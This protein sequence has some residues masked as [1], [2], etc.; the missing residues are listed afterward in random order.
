MSM[1]YPTRS[2]GAIRFRR[3]AA[4]RLTAAVLRLLRDVHP[5][6][7]GREVRRGESGQ[8]V[9]EQF[10]SSDRMR[11]AGSGAPDAKKAT[12]RTGSRSPR[13]EDSV[14]YSRLLP[15]GE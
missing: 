3:R 5:D 2:L 1:N 11:P 13:E 9:I 4:W 12:V 14:D 10:G 8:K 6:P 15:F 7:A